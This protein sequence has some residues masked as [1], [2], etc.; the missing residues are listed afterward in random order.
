MGI[1]IDK[2]ISNDIFVL[3]ATPYPKI[4]EEGEGSNRETTGKSVVGSILL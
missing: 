4:G 3:F 1:A 2:I